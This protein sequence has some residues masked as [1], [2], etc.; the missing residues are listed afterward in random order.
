MATVPTT[1]LFTDDGTFPNSRLP[2]IVYPGVTSASDLAA[3]FEALFEKNGWGGASWRNGLFQAHHYHSRAHEVLGIYSGH[4]RI[5]LGGPRSDTLITARAG[6][7]VV[8][9]AGVAHMN[10]GAST[11]YRVVG[12]Y[13]AGTSPDLNF[14]KRG[15]RP[16]TDLNIAR[17]ATPDTDPVHGKQGALVTH[18]RR[19]AAAHR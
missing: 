10:A 11:D 3:T 13:P 5:H 17:L 9:P 6:D 2:V 8:I 1:Y 14:G 7:V 4:V 19:P 12:A 15:E 18:W 16:Q